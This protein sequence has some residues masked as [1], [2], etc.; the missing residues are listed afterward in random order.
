VGLNFGGFR[1]RSREEEKKNRRMKCTG[2][3]KG[4]QP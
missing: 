2:E 4:E 3:D 1:E